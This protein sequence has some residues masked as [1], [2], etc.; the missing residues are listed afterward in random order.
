MNFETFNAK[1]DVEEIS[2]FS[3]LGELNTFLS[4][5]KSLG[6]WE[7]LNKRKNGVF[8][9]FHP[10]PIKSWLITCNS[11][12]Q[13]SE[14][15]YSQGI[16]NYFIHL[17]YNPTYSQ[18]S[19]PR[20]QTIFEHSPIKLTKNMLRQS[21]T[22]VNWNNYRNFQKFELFFTPWRAQKS[23]QNAK[24]VFFCDF[25]TSFHRKHGCNGEITTWNLAQIV[26]IDGLLTRGS[27]EAIKFNW[28]M[29]PRKHRTKNR[30]FW[31]IPSVHQF[32][33]LFFF[34][35]LVL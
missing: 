20:F 14:N 30:V 11:N 35:S 8:C 16:L 25:L 31:L 7:F 27:S 3:E 21:H 2:K 5:T 1:N 4:N 17:R 10:F 23:V 33:F 26:K 18:S 24:M 32:I 15:T 6:Y 22:T 19:K 28:S 9:D 34:I 13:N 29:I 12:C